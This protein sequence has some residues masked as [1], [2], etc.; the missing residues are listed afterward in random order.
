M[1][2]GSYEE[3]RLPLPPIER[4]RCS[5]VRGEAP[6]LATVGILNVAVPNRQP[7]LHSHLLHRERRRATCRRP[8]AGRQRKRPTER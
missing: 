2:G 5:L 1:V 4:R 8:A 6:A 7:S 3:R